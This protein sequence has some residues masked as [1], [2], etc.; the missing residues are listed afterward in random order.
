MAR[1]KRNIFQNSDIGFMFINRETMDSDHFNRSIGA[2]ANLR[3]SAQMDVNAYIA[4]TATPDL[5]G[6]DLAGRVAYSYNSRSIIFSSSFSTL[7][8]NFNPEVGFAPRTGV[9]RASGRCQY[10]YRQ[11]WARDTL[12]ELSATA[13]GDYF[14]DQ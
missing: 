14:T 7:Q 4:K 10:N 6:D 3:L 2:D 9:R 8:D 11:P 12:R 1:V 13:E 5:E